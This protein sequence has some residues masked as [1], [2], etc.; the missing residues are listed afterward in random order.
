MTSGETSYSTLLRCCKSGRQTTACTSPLET[1]EP[2][3]AFRIAL[4]NLSNAFRSI[5]MIYILS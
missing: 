4:L 5:V 2:N 3:A 1:P